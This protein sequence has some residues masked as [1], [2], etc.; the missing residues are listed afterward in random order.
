MWQFPGHGSN[1]CHSCNQSQSGDNAR[2]LTCWATRELPQ[3]ILDIFITPIRNSI[4]LA[5]TPQSLHLPSPGHH[6][7]TSSGY[8]F[9]HSGYFIL[10]EIYNIRSFVS[11]TYH[12]VFKVHPCCSIY[13]LIFF[14]YC[15]VVFH[16]VD[17]SHFIY[18]SLN[19]Q[20]FRLFPSFGYSWMM[21]LWT[22]VDTCFSLKYIPGV[23]LLGYMVIL[24]THLRNCQMIFHTSYTLFIPPVA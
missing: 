10:M 3:S 11:F 14:F 19:W 7:S 22:P 23:E 13:C 2:S 24:F 9:T 21:L 18:S 15:W 6:S 4:P 16:C 5:L 17:I 12:D 8:R 20:I 1:L